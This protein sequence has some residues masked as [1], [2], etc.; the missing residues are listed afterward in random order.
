[1]ADV[2]ISY[3]NSPERRALVRRLAAILRAHEVTV[4]WDYGLEAGESY[5][6]QITGRVVAVEP[7]AGEP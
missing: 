3:R 4:W 7:R 1:M 5:R 2:F 6:T